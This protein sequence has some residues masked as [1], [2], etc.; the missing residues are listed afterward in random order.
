MSQGRQGMKPQGGDFRDPF[1]GQHA[2]VTGKDHRLSS[3]N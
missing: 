2:T 1:G 3:D